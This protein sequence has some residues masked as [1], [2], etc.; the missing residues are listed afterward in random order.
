[1]QQRF[2]KIVKE[3]FPRNNFWRSYYQQPGLQANFRTVTNVTNVTQITKDGRVVNVQKIQVVEETSITETQTKPQTKQKSSFLNRV[4]K[5]FGGLGGVA[6]VGHF[7]LK[8]SENKDTS[9]QDNRKLDAVVA[10]RKAKTKRNEAETKTLEAQQKSLEAKTKNH[11]AQQKF[12]ETQTENLNK[13]KDGGCTI[14]NIFDG[15]VEHADSIGMSSISLTVVWVSLCVKIFY[16]MK[17]PI[18]EAFVKIKV[19]KIGDIA[20][21]YPFFNTGTIELTGR[22]GGRIFGS[23][24]TIFLYLVILNLTGL[25]LYAVTVKSQLSTTFWFSITVVLSC[26]LLG[27][28]NK[29]LEFF[30]MF[31]NTGVEI[32]MR[33][34][35]LFVEV[36]SFCIR[37]VSYALRLFANLLSGHILLHLFAKVIN[38]L[39]KKN[40]LL[41]TTGPFTFLITFGV[42][43]TLIAGLQSFI[44]STLF[45]IWSFE[46]F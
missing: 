6:T 41:A 13:K 21:L 2:F 23:Y 32:V 37:P 34:L 15:F 38:V 29:G 3:L 7:L 12:Y 8:E 26:I 36:L 18:K 22:K 46:T 11:E 43:E 27:I 30:S 40:K 17:D 1:M 19:N 33:V 28:K 25:L 42:L 39:R 9:S 14:S 31:W 5:I 44:P 24:L 10:E 20:T 45:Q 4:V 35:L 16:E